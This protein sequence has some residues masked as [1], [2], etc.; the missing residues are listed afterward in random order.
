MEYT[1]DM[2]LH[3]N[4]GQE[5]SG[6]KNR[7]KIIDKVVDVIKR[8]KFISTVVSITFMLMILDFMLIA[9]FV[10]VLSTVNI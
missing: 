9:S 7:W 8:H 6:R 4:Y 2:I 3:V 1:K 10:Q 5:S